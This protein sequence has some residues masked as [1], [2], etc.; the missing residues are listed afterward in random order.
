MPGFVARLTP[1]TTD[2]RKPG[3][4]ASLRQPLLVVGHRGSTRSENFAETLRAYHLAV[5]QKR[6]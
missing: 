4:V 1:R 2:T 6:G 3:S 5:P